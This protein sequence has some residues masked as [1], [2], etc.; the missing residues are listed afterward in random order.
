MS[1]LVNVLVVLFC[2]TL[3]YVFG[4]IP[5]SIWVGKIFFHQDP[6]DF[7]SHNAGGT[8]A[9]RLWGKKVGFGIILF[10]MFKTI[11]PVWI[12]WALL[13]FLPLN[14][15]QSL[16]APL[17]EVDKFGMSNH[18]VAWPAYWLAALGCMF[19][20]C[21]PLFA[22]FKGGKGVSCYM[23]V[24]T[25]SS[26]GLGFIPGLLYFVILK[27]KKYVSLASILLSIIGALVG[28]IWFLLC[29]IEVIPT[30]MFFF[31]MYGPTLNANWVYASVLT[32]M[33]II[34]I[35]RHHENIDRLKSGT[36]R[37][38]KWMK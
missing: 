35:V 32:L 29:S 3:G 7:G 28:W 16:I 22:G 25:A 14:N 18:I 10:D 38:I 8:N 20:H 24:L 1:I 13:T 26:W 27:W 17:S 36:E 21:W 37:K 19:G 34:L 4:S 15:G 31:P 12:C 23:G 30:D 11:T 9:G 6:R 2:L 5:T 33:S